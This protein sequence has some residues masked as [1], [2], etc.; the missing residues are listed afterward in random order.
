MIRHISKMIQASSK[1]LFILALAFLLV[2]NNLRAQDYL[3]FD[4]QFN[5]SYDGVQINKIYQDSLGF[6]WLATSVGLVR[7]DGQKYKNYPLPNQT[8]VIAATAIYQCPNGE[9]WVG[10][11]NGFLAKLENHKLSL[12]DLGDNAPNVKITGILSQPGDLVWLATY[13]EGLY[14]FENSTL[15]NI[16]LEQGL[17]DNFIYTMLS[18][19]SDKIWIGTD[20]GISVCTLSNDKVIIKNYDSTNGLKDNIV[21]NLITSNTGD[22]VIGLYENGVCEYQFNTQSFAEL[23]SSRWTNGPINEMAFL[24]D[25]VLCVASEQNGLLRYN[26][27]TQKIN[28][29]LSPQHLKSRNIKCLL[30]DHEGSIWFAD[31]E[32]NLNRIDT[33]FE[34]HKK[35]YSHKS[36]G[37]KTFVI[38]NSGNIWYPSPHGIARYNPYGIGIDTTYYQNA[39]LPEQEKIISSYFDDFGFLWLGTYE[40]GVF[41]YDPETNKVINITELNGL[42]N[43]NVLS[44]AGNGNTIWFATLGGVTKCTIPAR[45]DQTINEIKFDN[46]HQEDG[47]GTNYIYQV[48]IDS[49]KRAWFATHGKGLTVYEN[50]RF[51]NFGSQDDL[52][53]NV[54]YSITEDSKQNILFS[55]AKGELYQYS[56]GA[57]S[58]IGRNSTPGQKTIL[59]LI[60]DNHGNTILVE[61]ENIG[62]IDKDLNYSS[63]KHTLGD[64]NANGELNNLRKDKEG[65]IW[66]SMN[67]GLIKH[68]ASSIIF[69]SRPKTFI[70]DIQVFFES[71][72]VNK[73]HKLSHKENHISFLCHSSWYQDSENIIY[74]YI[75]EGFDLDWNTSKDHQFTY[76][77]LPP[78]DYSFKVKAVLIN[79]ST[80]STPVQ[81][82]FTIVSPIW[83]RAWF[84]LLLSFFLLFGLY[85]FIKLREKRLKKAEQ[86]QQ[87]IISFQFETLKSQVNPHFLFNSFNTLIAIIEDNQRV[88]VE[89]VSKLSDFFRHVLT[90]RDKQVITLEEELSLI[91]DYYF[92]QQKRYGNNFSLEIMVDE[93]AKQSFIP[94]LTLQLLTENAL[95]H[96]TVS[97]KWPLSI[98]IYNRNDKLHVKNNLNPKTYAE[99]STGFGLE[100]IKKRYLLLSDKKIQ[101]VESN[102]N[103]EVII[104]LLKSD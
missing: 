89:Y 38:D 1:L 55:T 63:Y 25:Q 97:K 99:K 32:S 19:K 26:L 98:N 103:F 79:R 92:L 78:G 69:Q 83:Q 60:S 20:R 50:E 42:A 88:A 14:Y 90:Y 102:D 58:N 57:F 6:I 68:P 100:N 7:Y 5:K 11:D 2:V 56:K 71:V 51:K 82:D 35:F 96:N 67:Q 28:Q 33:R 36:S 9:L 15:Y 31:S 4:H 73:A 95:K 48:F 80:A 65:N 24:S 23:E 49:K 21:K 94:P 8:D 59:G 72:D 70:D 52:S 37:L 16:N 75:L 22:L 44:I 29:L 41:R 76:P 27:K 53:S 13:G 101:I 104:P 74:E 93:E 77:K 18:D 3:I 84:Y 64:I 39:A 54:I 62:L 66:I 46:F 12:I 81:F 47:L 91:N 45:F 61:D 40:Y 87:E 43:D 85:A 86:L 30:K 10:Y 17:N 34:I